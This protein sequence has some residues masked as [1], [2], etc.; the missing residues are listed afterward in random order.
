VSADEPALTS[1]QVE[2][3]Q[4][5]FGLRAS[6]GVLLAGGVALLS[7]GLAYTENRCCGSKPKARLVPRALRMPAS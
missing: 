6:D 7:R 2:V 4:A 3:A 5:F 1:F